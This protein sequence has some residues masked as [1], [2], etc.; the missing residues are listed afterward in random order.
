[1]SCKEPGSGRKKIDGQNAS[2]T[3]TQPVAECD[4]G[5]RKEQCKKL[6]A[7]FNQAPSKNKSNRLTSFFTDSLLQCWYGTPWDFNGCTTAP[8]QGKIACGYF[9]TTTLQDAGVA[10]NRIK[11][12]QCPS[13]KLIQTVCLEIKTY[14]NKPIEYFINE[15]KKSGYGLYL[16]GLDFHTCFI[17]N[18]GQDVYFIHASYYATKCVVK[19]KAIDCAV[20]QNSKLR[21]TGK[22]NFNK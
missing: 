18:D 1:M 6:L 20:L 17:Y 8:Q 15:I 3:N 4:Y 13:S 14:S 7:A 9:I 22:V 21:I 10:I 5:S 12:A 16:A 19:E 11:M 2:A